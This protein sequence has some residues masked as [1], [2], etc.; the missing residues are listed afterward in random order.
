MKPVENYSLSYF[1][2]FS[3]LKTGLLFNLIS[4]GSH[5]ITNDCVSYLQPLFVVCYY[6]VT[7]HLVSQQVF[8]L[9][10]LAFAMDYIFLKYVLNFIV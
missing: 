6:V 1:N 9:S 2:D 5:E 10:D 7:K 4:H 8:N 3:N